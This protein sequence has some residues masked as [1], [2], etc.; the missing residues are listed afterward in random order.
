MQK[1][2]MHD[3][4]NKQAEDLKQELITMERNFNEKKELLSLDKNIFFAFT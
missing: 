1:Q 2:E 3:D 4:L